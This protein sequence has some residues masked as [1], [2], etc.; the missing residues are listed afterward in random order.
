MLHGLPP[1]AGNDA[2]VLILG[3]FPSAESLRLG[4]YY[5]HPRNHFWPLMG[6]LFHAAVPAEAAAREGWIVRCGVAIWDSI[7]RCEREGS[8]DQAIR[9]AEA[10]DVAGFLEAHPGVVRILLN[11]AKSFELFAKRIA[12][13]VPERIERMRM[14]STSPVPSRSYRKLEDKLAE[15]ESGL[16]PLLE[17]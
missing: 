15:W 4:R 10:N 11:G 6:I 17:R 5:A 7:G 16:A 9:N 2:R 3:S 1:L 12:P 13:G 14:P 8:L